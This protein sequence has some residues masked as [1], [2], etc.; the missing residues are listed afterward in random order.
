MSGNSNKTILVIDDEGT[1]RRLIFQVLSDEGYEVITAGSYEEAIALHRERPRVDLLVTDVTL[2]GKGGCEIAR[3]L[4]DLQPSLRVLYM[5]GMAGF[6]IF[7]F[8]GMPPTGA[9]FLQKPFRPTDLL[10]HVGILLSSAGGMSGS[11]AV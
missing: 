6:E 5:S 7:R 11:A 1:M 3:T 2:P 4:L 10:R 8:Y 9:H